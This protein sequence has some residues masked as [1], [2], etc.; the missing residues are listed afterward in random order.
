MVRSLDWREASM[1]R[2]VAVLTFAVATSAARA[3]VTDHLECYTIKDPLELAAVVD[4]DAGVP[5]CGSPGGSCIDPVFGPTVGPSYWSSTTD[6]GDAT[7]VDRRFRGRLR[8][9]QGEA[10]LSRRARGPRRP[11][12]GRSPSPTP[13]DV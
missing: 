9:P 3:Q 1:V 11:V 4:L 10:R 13:A 6:A 5:G 8:D 12:T 7:R 2:I